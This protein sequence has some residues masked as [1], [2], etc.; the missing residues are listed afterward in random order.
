MRR[1][2]WK[3]L[4][5]VVGAALLLPVSMALADYAVGPRGRVWGESELMKNT[6]TSAKYWGRTSV[7]PDDFPDEMWIYLDLFKGG[8]WIGPGF[9]RPA[10][11]GV[12]FVSGSYEPTTSLPGEWQ[13]CAWHYAY[14]IPEILEDACSTYDP[15]I[16]SGRASPVNEYLDC[17]AER[18]EEVTDWHRVNYLGMTEALQELLGA[19]AGISLDRTFHMEL[20]SYM[21]PYDKYPGVLLAPD[22]T[23]AVAL[24]FHKD[25]TV[26]VVTLSLNGGSKWLM[27][28]EKVERLSLE[29]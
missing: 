4:A 19:S 27:V 8:E 17:Y 9:D 5:L 11:P 6:P 12:R 13:G 21:K 14:W 22:G 2:R 10:L 18:N 26:S 7:G 16:P 20:R 15:P 1:N 23:S 28:S 25:E 29:D 3:L 24:F